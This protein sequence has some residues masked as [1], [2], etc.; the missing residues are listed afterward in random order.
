MTGAALSLVRPKPL[1]ASAPTGTRAREFPNARFPDHPEFGLVPARLVTILRLAEQGYP[2]Q[3]CA[4]FDGVVEGDGHLRDVFDHRVEQVAGKPRQIQE[5]GADALSVL[6]AQVLR[7]A[8]MALPLTEIHEHLLTF[9]RYGWAAAEIDW[10]V[11][12]IGGVRAIV[13]VHVALVP[14]DRFRIDPRTD[15]L[16]LITDQN[17]PEGEPLEP[18]KWIVLRRGGPLA[19][20]GLMRTA[21]WYALYKRYGTRDWVVFA[22]KFG[23]PL[24]IV[25]YDEAQGEDPKTVAA[26]IADNI[27]NDGAA[28]IPKGIEVKI[29]DAARTSGSA[30]H[31]PLI[32][33][34]NSEN[35]KLV[36]GSTLSNDNADGGSSYALGNVH[37]SVRH[38]RVIYDATRLSEAFL[39]HVSIP[40]CVFNGVRVDDA[41]RVAPMLQIQIAPEVD[42]T[43]RLKQMATAKNELGVTISVEQ[44]RQEIGLRAPLSEQ[45]SAP[46]MTPPAPAATRSAP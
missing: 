32:A 7:D 10:D 31:E 35:S 17:K 46:G 21:V 28:V 13:P 14:A 22:E 34:C 1:P 6:L 16:R 29:E 36:N 5:R 33:F 43:A 2:A 11:R 19:R 4:L 24:P 41:P 8:W 30:V 38:E 18:G 40:F 25:Q 26:D 45:D 12:V 20:A 37:A 3:Q 44:V 15:E 23:I 9:N 39:R 27:G 42:P